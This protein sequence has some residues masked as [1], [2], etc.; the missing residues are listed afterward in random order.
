LAQTGVQWVGERLACT[1]LG[2]I[3]DSEVGRLSSRHPPEDRDDAPWPSL[4]GST[5][6]VPPASFD[7]SAGNRV[8]RER[9]VGADPQQTLLL[10]LLGRAAGAPL[11]YRQL[12]D[13]GIEYPASV[14]SELELSGMPLERA[15]DGS[16]LLGVR[17]DPCRAPVD[18][19]D[20]GADDE[21]AS[22]RASTTL[23]ERTRELA[24]ELERAAV[25]LA[26]RAR[27]ARRR[28]GPGAGAALHAARN[29]VGAARVRLH[30]ARVA[31]RAPRAGL[32]APGGGSHAPGVWL[33]SPGARWLAP[34]ALLAMAAL[35]ATL[36]VSDLGATHRGHLTANPRVHA[37]GAAVAGRPRRPPPRRAPAAP[38]TQVSPALAAA[39]EARGHDLL[40][41]GQLQT[42]IPVLRQALQATGEDLAGC[43]EP[44]RET[45][46]TYAYALYDLGRALRLDRQATAAVPLLER[47]LQIANERPIVQ[48]ELAL[49][50]EQAARPLLSPSGTG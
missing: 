8:A 41:S 30:S 23:G 7:P 34:S 17:L 43:R 38:P 20:I 35:V 37:R 18:G 42:A 1:A 49:A 26:A 10:E 31:L 50:R 3:I 22:R 19:T 36:V 40:A 47:R 2:A 6:G 48:A 25:A 32:Q 16:R 11:S 45:C 21:R 27:R 29:R 46:L 4:R 15:Y 39:L 24:G 9:L 12:N 28:M 33:R 5:H 44:V 13:A 14:V